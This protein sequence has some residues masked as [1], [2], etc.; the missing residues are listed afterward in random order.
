MA[1]RLLLLVAGLAL[2]G[3]SLSLLVQADLGVSPWD[4]FHQGVARQLDVRLGYVLIAT[5]FAVLLCWI[6]LRVRPGLGT[7]SNAVLVGLALDLTL[8]VLPEPDP[9]AARSAFLA[10]GVV[11]NGV[12]TGMYIGAGLG[13]GPRDGLMTGLAARGHSVRVVR[14]SIEVAVLLV[15]AVLGGTLGVGTIVYALAIGP[16]AHVFIPIFRLREDGEGGAESEVSAT[17]RA[18]S[19]RGRARN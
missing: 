17:R 16:L 13:P 14:T 19:L 4:V 7:I 9:L 6:P 5:S 10:L 11:L 2:Y 12:A 18:A 8:R 1:R 15:G 3:V